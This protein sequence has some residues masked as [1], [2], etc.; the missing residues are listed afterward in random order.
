MKLMNL[1]KWSVIG[2]LMTVFLSIDPA[3]VNASTG[4]ASSDTSVTQ[5]NHPLKRF[6]H[7]RRKHR[8][9]RRWKRHHHRRMDTNMD[10]R[11]PP[12]NENK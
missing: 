4:S 12:K 2:A 5:Q 6:R 8:R 9:F 11:M 10:K 7:N 3:L 1:I